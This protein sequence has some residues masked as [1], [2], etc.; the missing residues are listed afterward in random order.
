[1]PFTSTTNVAFRT[2]NCDILQAQDPTK[3]INFLLAPT[4]AGV[5]MSNS[6]VTSPSVTPGNL[7]NIASG[8]ISSGRSTLSVNG[9]KARW[10]VQ[11]TLTPNAPS[12]SQP[13][14][15][16]TLT[17]PSRTTG[18]APAT[19]QTIWSAYSGAN[20][21]N[22]V[23]STVAPNGANQILVN[24]PATNADASNNVDVHYINIISEYDTN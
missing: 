12:T 22:S 8:S 14:C 15:S 17:L 3:P 11:V 9:V 10:S 2:V 20:M 1:M 7:T 18:A 16:F 6:V 24:F 23:F 13:G 21:N 19:I 5:A 4:V